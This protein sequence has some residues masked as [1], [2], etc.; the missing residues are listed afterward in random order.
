V[1]TVVLGENG[2]AKA[3]GLGR[4]YIDMSTDRA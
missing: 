3:L 2:L 1:H 4:V